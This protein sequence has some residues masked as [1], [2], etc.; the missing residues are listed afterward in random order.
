MAGAWHTHYRGR[1]MGL[2][3]PLVYKGDLMLETV[4]IIG[5]L[6]GLVMFLTCT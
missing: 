6:V 4:G 5:F 1:G 2:L 3:K